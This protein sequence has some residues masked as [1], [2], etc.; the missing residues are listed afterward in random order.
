MTLVIIINILILISAALCLAAYLSAFTPSKVRVIS[1]ILFCAAAVGAIGAAV[2]AAEA[3]ST[4]AVIPA[5][6]TAFF[7]TI[8]I[9]SFAAGRRSHTALL[10]FCLTPMWAMLIVLSSYAASVIEENPGVCVCG[11]FAATVLYLI[12]ACDFYRL[13]RRMNSDTGIAEGRK[14]RANKRRA[15]R[16]VRKKIAEKRKELMYKKRGK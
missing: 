3:K 5:A 4:G 10:R 12:P 11:C 16:E 6:E 2:C 1:V 7:L 15:K 14:D 8:L 9:I 13:F